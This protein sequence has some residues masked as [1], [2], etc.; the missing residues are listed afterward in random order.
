M[1]NM[2]RI[3]QDWTGKQEAGPAGGPGPDYCFFKINNDIKGVKTE[4]TMNA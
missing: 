1:P 3:S 4:A 2:V